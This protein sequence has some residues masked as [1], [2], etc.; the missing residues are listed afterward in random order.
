MMN[1]MTIEEK[2]HLC[3][4]AVAIAV[5]NFV[6]FGIGETIIGGVADLSRSGA[7]HYFV[8]N[9]EKFHE[10]SFPIFIYSTIHACSVVVTHVTGIY[11]GRFYN[12]HKPP[13]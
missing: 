1:T 5:I 11:A 6:A 7:G 9:H 3:K 8:A 13:E 4:L 10:V 2:L 12:K